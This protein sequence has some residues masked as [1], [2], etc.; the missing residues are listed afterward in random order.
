M[1]RYAV[2]QSSQEY[3]DVVEFTYSGDTSHFTRLVTIGGQ[4]FLMTEAD[5]QTLLHID[6]PVIVTVLVERYPGADKEFS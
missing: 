5:A 6:L 4:Q 3:H 1:P 2:I